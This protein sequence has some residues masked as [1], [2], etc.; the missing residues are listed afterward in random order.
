MAPSR[1]A[2]KEGQEIRLE[3][4]VQAFKNFRPQTDG[5]RPLLIVEGAGGLLV[6][7]TS[8]H[9]IRDLVVA[10]ELPLI[11]VA[12]TRLGTM[13]HLF[14]SREAARSAGIPVLG[15][16]LVGDEDP[17]LEE[18]LTPHLDV[19]IL[20]RIP[21]MTAVTPDSVDRA[22][23]AELG[24]AILAR[25][26]RQTP[27]GTRRLLQS[28]REIVWHP[29][30]QHGLNEP[31]LPV[32]SG[33]GAYLRLG[34][35][36]EVIDGI[37]SWWVNLHGHSHPE[38]A[39][40]IARQAHQLE[41]VIFAG[42]THQ[43]AVELAELLVQGPSVK[44]M[45]LTRVFYSDNGSTAVEVA[46]KMAYQF[47]H[48][49]GQKQ[50][51]RFLALSGAYHG[52]T[53]GAMAVGEPD[54]FHTIFRTL[55]PQVDFVNPGDLTQLKKYLHDQPGV[56]AAFIFEPGVQGSAG[57]KS[58]CPS[59][60]AEAVKLCQA[61]GILTIADEVFTGFYRTGKFLASETADLQPDLLCLSK[62]ITGGFLPLAVTLTSER[63]FEGFLSP[64]VDQAF[65]HGHSYTANPIACAAAV[66]S[67]KVL[68]SEDCQQRISRIVH[69]TEREVKRL[70]QHPRVRSIRHLG[71]IGVVE[72]DLSGN[73]FQGPLKALC[74][75]ALDQGVFLRP[76]GNV[77]YALPP[78]CVTEAELSQV[79]R[80]MG[81][82]L[83]LI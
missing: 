25:M 26:E 64:K 65:L 32:V 17:E 40:A 83:D 49:R 24:R 66:A 51:Q 41:H 56:Y 3:P 63:I 35:G 50:R 2:Q 30:S 20:A 47:Q 11:L 37:S 54:G 14:L 27:E 13:N 15:V 58:V 73:Y 7:I 36:R 31:I 78:Y 55:L 68:H 69:Q 52:D 18:A 74:R 80:V 19:P 67:W 21:Q 81:N 61:A 16:L 77:L 70:G 9:T 57:M 1:A 71:T 29:Y 22:A 28:D 5:G 59:F 44:A 76:L 79:Y 53:L 43:P 60:L 42:F 23:T 33:R 8:Q 62:G 48:Q 45:N 82:L 46:L 72:V 10:L 39:A 6:P 75:K 12:S 34:D 38:V 4:I